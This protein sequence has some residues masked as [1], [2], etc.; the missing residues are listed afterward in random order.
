[1]EIHQPTTVGT[2]E[3]GD[4]QQIRDGLC[5]NVLSKKNLLINI[6]R[7]RIFINCKNRIHLRSLIKAI[8]RYGRIEMRED[9]IGGFAG[10]PADMTH[11]Y[12]I[13]IP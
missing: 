11:H 8:S 1:M 4:R 13:G 6:I 7:K 12:R 3:V 5:T 10:K 2:A 9:K